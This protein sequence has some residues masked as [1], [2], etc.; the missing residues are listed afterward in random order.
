MEEDDADFQFEID[1]VVRDL[2]Q[3]NRKRFALAVVPIAL[4]VILFLFPQ[5]Y[6]SPD[7]ASGFIPTIQILAIISLGFSGAAVIMVYLQT[8]FKN[9][10]QFE[11][12]EEARLIL[13][14]RSASNNLDEDV[15]SEADRVKLQLDKAINQLNYANEELKY[16]SSLAAQ[17]G[18]QDK[19]ALIANLKNQL[20]SETAKDVLAEIEANVSISQARI[21][22]ERE[23]FFEFEEIRMRLTKEI[24]ALGFRGNVNL[25][26][27]AITTVI[28]LVILGW[29]VFQ[30][31]T[32]AVKDPWVMASHFLPR[33]TLV[34]LIEL[35]AFFFLSLY[36]AS[37][38]EIKY[39]QNELTNA[40]S[41]H[42]ALQTSI[43]YGDPSMIA[44]MVQSLAST[45][46]NYIL[47]KDQST[48]A[49]EK[50]KIE[51]ATQGDFVRALQ[52]LIK[53]SKP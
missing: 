24:E 47:T 41:K 7:I 8:G 44:M 29:G 48:A 36:K 37:L 53:N 26:L 17:L 2:Q 28:G 49:L 45:E 42:I 3:R 21:E 52:D 51:R 30:E 10:D 25:T 35:F 20:T 43:K 15:K 50:A 11:L 19:D 18:D 40:E 22:K 6:R 9:P 33:L 32:S 39:F 31:V 5:F 38:A 1:Q 16:S 14:R 23:L 12:M 27:G 13:H 46:R 4:S 34:I